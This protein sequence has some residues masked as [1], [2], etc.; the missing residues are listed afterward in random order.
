[1]RKRRW[2]Y[3]IAGLGL[4]GAAWAAIRAYRRQDAITLWARRFGVPRSVLAGV[5]RTESRGDPQAKRLTGGDARR[6]GAWG[7]AQVTLA[8]AR[9]LIP[10]IRR[11]HPEYG[12]ILDRFDDSGPS[13]FDRDLNLLV[14]AF[15]LGSDQA[16]LGRWD[17]AVLAYNRGREGARLYAGDPRSDRYVAKV[18]TAA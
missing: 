2:I 6:G 7:L 12:R 1:M 18:L 5:V 14:A 11:Q 17:L 4:V 10:K 8:T 16:A 9:E 13:L 15:K 3:A